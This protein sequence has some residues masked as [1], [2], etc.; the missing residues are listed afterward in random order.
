MAAIPPTAIELL[1]NPYT[2]A[3]GGR[4]VREAL[5]E[6]L[7]SGRWVRL[8]ASVAFAQ[9]TGNDERI[10]AGLKLFAKGGGHL[11]LTFGADIFG[12]GQ[13]GSEYEAIERLLQELAYPTVCIYLYREPRRTF[14]PK[15]YLFDDAARSTAY[16]IIGSSNWSLG[17]HA[18]NVEANVGLM[19]DAKNADKTFYDSLSGYF[20]DYWRETARTILPGQGF[21]TLVTLSTLNGRFGNMLGKAQRKSGA[22]ATNDVATN[23][24]SSSSGGIQIPLEPLRLRSHGARGVVGGTPSS[25]PVPAIAIVELSSTRP[26]QAEVRTR[27]YNNYFR[28]P[29]GPVH[30]RLV[31][32]SGRKGKFRR[33]QTSPSNSRNFRLELAG[34]R[35]DYTHGFPVVMF[36]NTSGRRFDFM[37]FQPDDPD[38]AIVKPLMHA[39][40]FA[41]HNSHP[42]ALLPFADLRA[43]WPSCPLLF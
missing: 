22:R 37:L 15:V 26:G 24:S 9:T 3:K 31:D 5:I 17:G 33:S 14:H 38:L 13:C 28:A 40:N 4:S 10:I 42:T 43:A 20:D 32:P 39:Y 35:P 30:L 12:N 19:L 23:M 36:R 25:Q 29:Q 1:V 8:R 34:V 2:K 27:L 7:R 6:Q 11:D 41:M 21:A 16:A 18:N